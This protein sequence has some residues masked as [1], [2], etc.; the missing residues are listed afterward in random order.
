[1]L[2]RI[3]TVLLVIYAVYMVYYPNRHAKRYTYITDEYVFDE[4]LQENLTRQKFNL[5]SCT[6]NYTIIHNVE[7]EVSPNYQDYRFRKPQLGQFL[8]GTLDT[9]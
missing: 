2:K 4:L 8:T 5:Q 6:Y 9:L 1:M 7:I 3:I